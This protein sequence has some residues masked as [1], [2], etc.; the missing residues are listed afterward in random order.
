MMFGNVAPAPLS[1]TCAAAG[2]AAQS[3]AARAIERV[4]FTES[5]SGQGAS[6]EHELR[7]EQELIRGCRAALEREAIEIAQQPHVR[8]QLVGRAGD[9]SGG[10]VVRHARVG[11]DE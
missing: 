9:D 7:L 11:I 5:S 10:F 1:C 4:V 2:A 3:S 8:G 6:L